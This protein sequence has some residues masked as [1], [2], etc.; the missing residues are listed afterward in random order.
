MSE[1]SPPAVAGDAAVGRPPVL[2]PEQVAAILADFQSW[3][4]AVPSVS[5]ESPPK[6]GAGPDLFTLLGELTALR[7]EVNLQTKAT[8]SQQEQSATSLQ[9]LSR[10][11][12]SLQE[13]QANAASA[14]D[15]HL[16]PALK[17]LVELHDALSVAG[18]EALRVQDLVLPSLREPTSD[19]ISDP[20]E[21]PPIP[22]TPARARWLG[23]RG[24]DLSGYRASLTT[25]RKGEAERAGQRREVFERVRQLLASLTSGYTMGLQ[26]IERAL[27][28]HGLDAIPTLGQPFD[29]ERMEAVEAVT[30]SGLPP[31]Q[32]VD[33]VQ[34]GYLWNGRVFRFARVRVAK[35]GG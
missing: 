26:R 27:K 30:E 21:L 13:G 32:V 6:V 15:E 35:N 9:L 4:S 29:P 2:T 5:E 17:T 3:L 12:D 24:P 34:R 1:S 31:G 23:V 28:Q 22:A 7:H 10:A 8:R 20:P 33:E 18:R 25:W 14:R 11:L 19:A 16:R